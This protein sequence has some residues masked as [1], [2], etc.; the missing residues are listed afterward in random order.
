VLRP[1][2]LAAIVIA[3][4]A[5]GHVGSQPRQVRDVDGVSQN[6]FAPSGTANVL[7][8][9]SS[10]CPISNGYAPEVQRLCSAYR[11]R[12]IFCALVYE[13][14]AKDAAVVRTHR[15]SF[16]YSDIPAVIDT[17]HR[18]AA[19]ANATVTPQAIVIAADGEVK[20]RGRID[21]RYA[22]LGKPRRVVTVHDLRDVLDAVLAGRPVLQP[23]TEPVGCFIPSATARSTPR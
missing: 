4:G 13:D 21:S 5:H 14:V 7:L 1:I 16:G 6:L 23:V 12:G 17:G 8:F 18:I 11:T 22:E 20:Y 10:D 9:V 2:I 3:S 19:S 15:E